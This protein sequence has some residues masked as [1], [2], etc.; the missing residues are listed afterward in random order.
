MNEMKPLK[1]A[2][3]GCNM[4]QGQ[5]YAADRLDLYDLVA[6]CDLVE[7]KAR[8]VASRTKGAAVY[9]DFV[10][11]LAETKPDVVSIATPTASH[12]ALTLQA[13]E[14]GVRGIYVE[15]PMAVHLADARKMIEACESRGVSLLVGH[16]RR[17]L[18]VFQTMRRLIESGTIGE[19]YMIRGQCAGDLLSDG[20]HTIDMMLYLL[21]DI[22]A[23]WVV[24]QVSRRPVDP[25]EASSDRPYRWTGHRYGHVVESGAMGLIQFANGV[26]GELLT[27]ELKYP[28]RQYQ[29]IEVFGTTGRLWRAGDSANPPLLLWSDQTGGWSE[30]PIDDD[31]ESVF[32][33]VFRQ[34]AAMIHG[35]ASHPMSGD[36]AIR[37]LELLLGIFESAR[38]NGKITLPLQQDR[39]PLELLIEDGRL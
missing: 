29:D 18:A 30:V 7:D 37:S 32:D 9:T 5:A 6:V 10:R 33:D 39:Y 15:K 26:R 36:R 25:V 16:Q 13:V 23:E 21:D 11:M 38:V 3:V 35:G 28:D 24:G 2:V 17:M 8:S 31:G 20:T 1:M 14:A 34:F 27:G 19:I 12:T 4:G 22:E